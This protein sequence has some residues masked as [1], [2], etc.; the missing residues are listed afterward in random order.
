MVQ[1]RLPFSTCHCNPAFVH[2]RRRL[3]DPR[4]RRA[5]GSLARSG[6]ERGNPLLHGDRVGRVR[7]DDAVPRSHA[8]AA[9]G[10][11][12]RRLARRLARRRGA[13][14]GHRERAARMAGSPAR[15]PRWRRR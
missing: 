4:L 8:G 13:A 9:A 5:L 11:R 14:V 2:G 15:E 3:A 7:M 6:V 12:L 10:A 1:L